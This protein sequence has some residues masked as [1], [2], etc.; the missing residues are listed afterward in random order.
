[1]RR[2][3]KFVETTVRLVLRERLL[4]ALQSSNERNKR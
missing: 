3:V 4:K 1:M 2:Q